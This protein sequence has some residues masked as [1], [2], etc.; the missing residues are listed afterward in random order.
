MDEKQMAHRCPDARVVS[1][2]TVPSWRFTLD[3]AGVATIVPDAA[4]SVEGLLW[5]VTPEDIR[6]LDLYE[7]VQSGCYRKEVIPVDA[8]ADERMALVYLSNRNLLQRNQRAGYM[9][10]ILQAAIDHS[11]SRD[12][13]RTLASFFPDVEGE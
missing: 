2:I 4:S 13:V 12:Y 9:A 8:N 5:S 3:A 1:V 11:F 6:S 10:R 7:G